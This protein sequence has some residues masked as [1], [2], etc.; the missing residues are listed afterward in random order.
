MRSFEKVLKNEW[1]FSVG[2]IAC[3]AFLKKQVEVFLSNIKHRHWLYY[4]KEKTLQSSIAIYF[5]CWREKISG[6]CINCIK[7]G[8]HKVRKNLY[9]NEKEVMSFFK[10]LYLN[11]PFCQILTSSFAIVLG[12]LSCKHVFYS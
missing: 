1:K 7:F 11:Y 8:H 4:N 5:V 2:T 6:T 10:A 12:L 3:W 9:S